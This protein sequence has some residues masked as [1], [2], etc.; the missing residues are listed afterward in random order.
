V[1]AHGNSE[2]GSVPSMEKG[3]WLQGGGGGLALEGNDG[4][5]QCCDGTQ[6]NLDWCQEGVNCRRAG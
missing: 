3:E 1:C 6:L 4:H 2:H 5:L